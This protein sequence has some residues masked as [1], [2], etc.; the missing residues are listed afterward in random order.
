VRKYG[1]WRTLEHIGISD[2]NGAN[3]DKMNN[4][5]H[6]LEYQDDDGKNNDRPKP[7]SKSRGIDEGQG[8]IR[9]SKG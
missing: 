3:S 7:K 4:A 5:I 1:G 9:K 2:K 6:K 8:E